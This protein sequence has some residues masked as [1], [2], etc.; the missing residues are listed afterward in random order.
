M[1]G[2]TRPFLPETV[3]PFS[4]MLHGRFAMLAHRDHAYAKIVLLKKLREKVA[5]RCRLERVDVHRIA[6]LIHLFCNIAIRNLSYI[7][8]CNVKR[9]RS[10][11]VT[12]ALFSFLAA[13]ATPPADPAVT[14]RHFESTETAGNGARWHIFLFDPSK[15][16]S[17]DQRI[18]LA[19]ADLDPGCDWVGAPR[20]EIAR[21]TAEQGARYTD[22]VLAAPLICE[23]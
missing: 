14:V 4:H 13:C 5:G 21:R 16:R 19:R 3:Q 17:L 1:F 10:P 6:V 11:V 9:S 20:P 18:A 15:P 23:G 2:E 12:L 8:K 7:A 22:T